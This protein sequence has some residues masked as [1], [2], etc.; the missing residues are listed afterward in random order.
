MYAKC[1]TEGSVDDSRK[2]FDWM[3]EQNVMSWT[4]IIAGYVQSGDCDKESIQLFCE[5]IE[6]HVAPNHFT[7]SSVLKVCGNLF[8]SYVG[9]QVYTHAVKK[10]LGLDNIVG[11]SLISM[12]SRSDRLEE[13]RKA[14]ESLFEKN[15]VS[16]NTM[17]NAYVK[18]L[19]SEEAFEILNEI[20]DTGVAVSA[21]TYA[22]VLSGTSS[23]G[24]LGK[25][26]QNH[27]RILK[28][29]FASNYCVCNALIS[30]YSRCGNIE[31][32]FQVLKEMSD[33]NLISWTSMI[34]D[35]ILSGFVPDRFTL[36]GVV[37]ACAEL[38]SWTLGTQL[39]SWVIRTGLASDVC[40]GCSLVD[41]YAK[42][43]TEG[44]ADDSRKVF[45]RMPEQN[46]MSWTAIITGYVQSGDCDKEAIRLFCQMIEGHVAQNHFTFAS[47]LKACGN[48]LNSYVGEQ[49]Y[50]HA[51][52]RGLGLVNIVGN[53]LIS[54]YSRSDTGIVVSAYT[55]ASLLNGASSIGAIGKGE[56]I[57]DRTLKSGFASN[58]CVCNALISMYSRFGN[59]EAAFQIFKEMSDRNL[60][61][62]TSMIT[63]FT[64]HGLAARALEIFLDMLRA[65]CRV[66]S[67][68]ELE[69]HAAKMILEQDPND[70]AAY[71]LL[72]NLYASA[73]QWKD[74]ADIR[75]SMKER[76]LMKEAGCSWIEVENVV[77]KFHVGETSHPQAR[78]IYGELD[79]LALNIKELGYV[80]DT[81]C[82]PHELDEEQKATNL[83]FRFLD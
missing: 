48:L 33:R 34:T 42:C 57:H 63:G 74:V 73:G 12:Y 43:T 69:E 5:M 20:E 51:V 28:S 19:N 52:K 9:E 55:Y 7:F 47:V 25:G 64:K 8:N 41:M 78:E 18:N 26:E 4:A 59:I 15:L 72:S 56:K 68:T 45:D 6:G 16:C 35:M 58:Y 70:P 10:G 1:T 66:H 54:M 62:W 39:H 22:S 37:S 44:S 3:P 21:Y 53:S 65:A 82:V 75:R 24:S 67:D 80:P 81:S 13:A 60:I 77:H 71:I 31:A 50:T 30:M 79:Q 17:V 36:S 29:G 38:E 49:V 23:I 40:V 32:A 2:V 27:G 11:N 14:F 46:V 83:E 61:C 76:N